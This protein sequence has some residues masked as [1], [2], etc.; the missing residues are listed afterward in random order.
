MILR[1]DNLVSRR[2]FSL[3]FAGCVLASVAV[4]T[5]DAAIMVQNSATMQSS[6]GG[7]DTS[8]T[9]PNFN[10][11]GG[12][13]L[14]VLYSGER[15]V[16]GSDAVDVEVTFDGLGV[17]NATP[18]DTVENEG[19][20]IASINYLLNP[21][22]TSGDVVVTLPVAYRGAATVLS[23]SG[24]TAVVDAATFGENLG[25]NSWD[26]TLNAAGGG[27]MILGAAVDNTF[28]ASATA[29]T[30]SADYIDNL[31]VSLPADFIPGSSSAG[32]VQGYGYVGV[33]GPFTQTFTPG[34]SGGN[35]SR[36]AGAYLTLAPE[37]T[38]LALMGLCGLGLV[39]RRRH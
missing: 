37:P 14:A 28:G 11:N 23:L 8:F 25:T 35:S 4:A 9:F 20:Q 24:V 27:G 31:S 39:G 34:T 7:G 16:S 32:I 17:T 38:S 18:L 36:N 29:P 10:M 5:G 1:S 30:F 19:A 13:F 12:T 15:A 22:S 26:E 21:T 2:A 33:S 6:A 3:A